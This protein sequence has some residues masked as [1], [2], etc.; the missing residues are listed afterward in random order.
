MI[1]DHRR[2]KRNESTIVVY[3]PCDSF[4][5]QLS[6]LPSQVDTFDQR[7]INNELMSDIIGAKH[8]NAV[9]HFRCGWVTIPVVDLEISLELQRRG[10]LPPPGFQFLPQVYC[11]LTVEFLRFLS[12]FLKFLI[13]VKFRHGVLFCVSLARF[14]TLRTLKS[15]IKY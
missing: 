2:E 8:G 14:R 7:I 6:G 10:K 12:S 1:A 3:D 11:Q 15:W 9:L 5:I 4:F 13:L